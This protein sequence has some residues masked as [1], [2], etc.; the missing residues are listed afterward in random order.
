[1]AVGQT[2]ICIK[3]GSR[4]G[5]DYVNRLQSM[6]DRHSNRD[7]RLVCF[8]DDA[9]GIDPKVEIRPLPEINIPN[10]VAW[11][12]WRK[13][14]LWQA[15]LSDLSGDILFLDLDVVVT[16][17]IDAFFDYKPGHYCVAENWTQPGQRI[18]NTSCYRFP[19][20]KHTYLFDDFN[21]DPEAILAKYRVSQQYISGEIRDMHFWPADWCLSF[22]HSLIPAWPLNFFYT[23]ALPETARVIAF[24]GKPDPDDAVVGQWPVTSPWKRLY[25]HVRPTPWIDEHWR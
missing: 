19:V 17:N 20:G 11:L 22:K 10:R 6:I 5:A 8:T 18:G 14:S 12:P 24:T 16:G 23:P 4:Y 25:K 1:M 2:V 9:D 7:T 3:W 13:V 21:R 15:P